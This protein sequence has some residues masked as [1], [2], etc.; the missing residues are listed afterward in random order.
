[1]PS[2]ARAVL[3][4]GLIAGTLDIG[5]NLIF[6]AFRHIT[7]A[8]VF[9]YIASGLTGSWAFHAGAASIVLGVAIHYTIAIVWT[10][11]FYFASW[12]MT[13]L[14]RHPVVCGLAYGALVYL[15]MNFVV[16]PLTQ[17]PRAPAA[18]TLA[19]RVSGV[20]A[21]LFCFGLTVALLTRVAVQ[22]G[23]R[24]SENQACV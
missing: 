4:I 20:L 2:T 9:Q 19:S 16:L 8:M 14:V 1:M 3:R 17:V 23:N 21:L 13:I 18:M 11:L 24:F 15:V 22:P 5:E 10:A 6:N 7:P 12:R